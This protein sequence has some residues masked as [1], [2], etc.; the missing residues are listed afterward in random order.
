MKLYESVK[1]NIW[2]SVNAGFIRAP[3]QCGYAVPGETGLE[4]IQHTPKQS[5]H[6]QKSSA[7][8]GT[9]PKLKV[10]KTRKGGRYRGFANMIENPRAGGV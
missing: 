1:F 2:C 9:N 8:P 4:S 7:F 6:K 5:G 3:T 10:G